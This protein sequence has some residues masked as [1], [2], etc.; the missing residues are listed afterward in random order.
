MLNSSQ[1][2]W[3]QLKATK[4]NVQ[5]RAVSHVKNREHTVFCAKVPVH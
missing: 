5:R 4:R 2:N 3:R 1:R